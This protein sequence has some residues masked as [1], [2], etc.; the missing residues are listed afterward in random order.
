M[1]EAGVLSGPVTGRRAGRFKVVR[2]NRLTRVDEVEG[3]GWG[4]SRLGWGGVG[5]GS[6]TH[7]TS[8]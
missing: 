5:G 7:P 6:Y 3:V 4:W 8:E 1:E 2:S